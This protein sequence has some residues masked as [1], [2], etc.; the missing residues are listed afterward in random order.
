MC[1]ENIDALRDGSTEFCG[2]CADVCER[3]AEV[4]APHIEEDHCQECAEA[5]RRCAD[6]CRA[7]V[8]AAGG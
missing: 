7:S 4:C 6:E 3:C 8:A 2:R 5:C 1:R